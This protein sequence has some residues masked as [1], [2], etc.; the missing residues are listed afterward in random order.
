M[1]VSDLG[2]PILTVVF[3]LQLLRVMVASLLSVYRDRMGAPLTQLALFIFGV[4]ALAFLAPLV[5][6]VLGGGAG[7]SDRQRPVLVTAAGVGVARLALQLIPD[8]V[9]HWLVATAGFVLFLWFVPIYLGYTR[10]TT[11]GRLFGPAFVLGGT[12]DAL[13]N[14]LWG[15]YDYAWMIGLVPVLFALLLAA[16]QF[17]LLWRRRQAQPAATSRAEPGGGPSWAALW[18]LLAF[19][20]ALFL[21]AVRW[22]NV[23]WQTTALPGVSGVLQVVALAFVVAGGTVAALLAMAAAGRPAAGWI[24]GAI[25]VVVLLLAAWL[26]G[27]VAA[28]AALAGLYAS[29]VVLSW[30]TRAAAQG[31]PHA[32]LGRTS[33]VWALA[34]ILF[35]LLLFLY[36]AAYDINLPFDNHLL[37]PVAALLLGA[38]GLGARRA[39]A[40][41]REAAAA[42]AAWA[43]ARPA[44]LAGWLGAIALV[45]TPALL[46][47]A[48]IR[49][50]PVAPARD[51]PVRVMSYNLHFGHDM[52]GWHDL[53]ALAREIETSGAD[54]VALQEVSRGW[55][56][57]SSTDMLT[58]LAGR[59]NMHAVF[60]PAADEAWGNAVLSRYPIREARVLALPRG[61]VPMARSALVTRVEFSAAT[62]LQIV[63]VHT[64]HIENPRGDEVR[65]EQ[66]QALLADLGQQPA[67]VIMG[68]FNATP[69]SAVY[70]AM[71]AGEL[72]DGWL[73]A[74]GDP[75][76]GLTYDAREPYK[77]IDYIWLSPDLR[78]SDFRATTTAGSDH[79][80]IALTVG[81]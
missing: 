45:L 19:G 64:H 27:P 57:N 56:I 35:T 75:G 51:L 24:E 4:M 37:L 36:Y 32:G 79:R 53:E 47:T 16:A 9:I 61:G 41:G 25:L 39:L 3:G 69:D 44:L 68:D 73:A 21:F 6:R 62:S 10:G 14:G 65:L 40:A 50:V 7:G 70:A 15:T 74:G 43:P 80:G 38:C 18:P 48:V 52:N 29:A 67:T 72:Q 59:L 13:I 33:V 22:Q 55:V 20:P 2:V 11:P 28:A 71:R 49:P 42:P 31:G 63:S 66:V 78:A 26:S 1:L 54:V 17:A 60:A 34:M 5:A 23:A 46:W 77:R 12:L 81:R 76:G 8:A 58:W 30:V